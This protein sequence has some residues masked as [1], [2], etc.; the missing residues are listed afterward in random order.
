MKVFTP[1]FF[2]YKLPP[3]RDARKE[4][5]AAAPTTDLVWVFSTMAGC[6]QAL[7]ADKGSS[8]SV[9]T[10]PRGCGMFSPS[11]NMPLRLA[12]DGARP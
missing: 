7:A 3:N 11:P 5:G 6:I 12:T 10:G 4:K 2:A 9:V 8:F 1:I